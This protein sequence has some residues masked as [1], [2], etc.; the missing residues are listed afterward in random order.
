MDVTSG[1]LDV[2]RRAVGVNNTIPR[3]DCIRMKSLDLIHCAQRLDPGLFIA[4][5]E[6]EVRVVIDDTPDIA[7]PIEGIC[8]AV[9]C[10]VSV[11]P[12]ST[13]FSSSRDSASPSMTSGTANCD[14]T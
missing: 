1:F 8:R 3:Y 11:W 12:S 4:L 14:G 6:I 9:V 5:R 13:T 7:W 2:T 10:C